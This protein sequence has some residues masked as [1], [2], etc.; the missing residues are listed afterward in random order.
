[1]TSMDRTGVVDDLNPFGRQVRRLAA[2]L[3][4]ALVAVIL[5]A[6]WAFLVP[7][8][9]PTLKSNMPLVTRIV[10]TGSDKCLAVDDLGGL[11][12]FAFG[13]KS[14]RIQWDD[15][16]TGINAIS[17]ASHRFCVA[18]DLKGRIAEVIDGRLGAFY[19]VDPKADKTRFGDRQ[20]GIS[21][22]KCLSDRFC[23]AGDVE[24]RIYQFD[25]RR[26][27]LSYRHAAKK[28]FRNQFG[29]VVSIGC[30]SSTQCLAGNRGGSLELFN[31]HNWA[32]VGSTGSLNSD[33]SCPASSHCLIATSDGRITTWYGGW[34]LSYSRL[35]GSTPG[36]EGFGGVTGI[37]CEANT[38]CVA[39]DWEGQVF[40]YSSGRWSAPHKVDPYLPFEGV[41]CSNYHRCVAWDFENRVYW[42]RPDGT[43]HM[44]HLFGIRD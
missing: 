23:L 42:L 2:L 43:V 37:A 35:K 27:V 16:Q 31:G 4:A 8:A 15:T 41:T 20:S 13:G 36:L 40:W 10:C 29:A 1:M 18:G 22:I 34:T 44:T 19:S 14:V 25:G 9:L 6:A 17:C 7:H 33:V 32:Q 30:S 26:W 3:A 5:F 24:G 21:A 28:K 12:R 11:T 38:S 39:T